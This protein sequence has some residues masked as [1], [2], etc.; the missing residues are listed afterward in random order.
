[1]CIRVRGTRARIHTRDAAPWV[2]AAV[3]REYKRLKAKRKQTGSSLSKPNSGEGGG[4]K[5]NCG[6]LLPG[7]STS[8][9]ASE[10]LSFPL[11]SIIFPHYFFNV[12]LNTPRKL[13]GSFGWSQKKKERQRERMGRGREGREEEGRKMRSFSSSSTIRRRVH[14]APRGNLSCINACHC[15]SFTYSLVNLYIR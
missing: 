8:E 15:L 5:E 4:G 13:A 3:E 6:T 9:R 10:K 1:M 2:H 12:P 14:T 11:F 7:S